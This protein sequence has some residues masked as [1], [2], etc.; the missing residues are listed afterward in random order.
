MAARS[1]LAMKNEPLVIERVLDAPVAL[2]WRALTD[3]DDM[4]HWYFTLPKF[5]ARVGFEFE[6]LAGKAET[7]Y[8]HRCKVTEAIPEKRLAYSWRYEGYPGD[9]LVTFELFAEGKKTRLRLTHTGLETFS[10]TADFAKANFQRGWTSIFGS[11]SAFLET[12]RGKV[13]RPGSTG[14]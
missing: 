2:V 8:L 5:E 4:R 11:L 6:F 14:A 12:R 7:K 9:S 1:N 13:A 10:G 3:V